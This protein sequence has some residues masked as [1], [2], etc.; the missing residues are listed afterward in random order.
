LNVTE[1]KAIVPFAQRLF[2]Q[3]GSIVKRYFQRLTGDSSAAEDLTQEVFLRVVRSG[4]GYEH[5]DRERAWIFRIARN[6][7]IDLRRQGLRAPAGDSRLE[8]LVAPRQN[9]RASL[10]E[11]LGLLPPEERDAFLLREIA[12]LG[13]AEIAVMTDSTVPGV[14]SRIYRARCA[15]REMLIPPAPNLRDAVT[16]HEEYD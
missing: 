4:S 11:G 3:H 1:S 7:F 5:R 15:L 10:R 14:R 9:A 13:Y 2:E 6:V 12:G 8:P 16:R